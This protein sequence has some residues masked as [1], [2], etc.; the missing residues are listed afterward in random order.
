MELYNLLEVEICNVKC[1][2]SC[3]TRNKVSQFLESTPYHHYGNFVPLSSWQSR[4]EI[5]DNIF[6]WIL[7]N[8]EEGVK[9]L[10]PNVALGKLPCGA[11]FHIVFYI[12]GHVRPIVVLLGH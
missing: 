7:R 11:P 10:G 2:I 6:P 1:I 8:H 9:T 12:F 5:Q 4:D 3:V